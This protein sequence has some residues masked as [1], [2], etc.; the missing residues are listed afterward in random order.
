MVFL[1]PHYEY[2]VFVSYSHGVRGGD[3]DTPLKDW[4]L[5]LIGRLETDIRSV[6]PEFDQLHIWRDEQIDPTIHLSDELRAKVTQSGILM[7]VMSPRYLGSAWCK[8]ELEWFRQQVEDR[9]RDQ[10]RVFVVRALPTPES[11]WPG[12]LRDER[13]H[14]LVGFRFHDASGHDGSDPMPYG[15]RGSRANNE[16]YVRELGRLRTALMK[17]LRE[18]RA[19]NE[20]RIKSTPSSAVTRLGGPRRIYLHARAE[21]IPVR[22]EVKKILKDD[23][24]EPLTPVIDLGRELSDL[25][26]ASR[27]RIETAIRCDA[28]ALLRGDADARFVGDLIDIG[29]KERERMQ[30][31]R[32]APL[33]CAV[34]DRSGETLPIDV[35]RYEIERFDLGSDDWRGK[36]RG[37]LDQS[38]T[39]QGA[40]L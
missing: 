19:K 24:I 27:V 31:A 1:L 14:A 11:S 2:D 12:F 21:H 20:R 13:G 18:L 15:W 22:E 16:A 9:R 30:L 5:E 8:D 32:G 17:R 23:G 35:S 28:L 36:F 26:R 7:V 10:G 6:D 38:R 39:Q 4:T 37:W 29:I 25:T 33:P 40:A 34:L 3:D